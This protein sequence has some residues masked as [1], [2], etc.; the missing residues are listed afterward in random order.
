MCSRRY[1]CQC[2]AAARGPKNTVTETFSFGAAEE[3]RTIDNIAEYR[4]WRK[5]LALQPG[6]K[7]GFFP[8]MG[9]LHEG[10]LVC[11]CVSVCCAFRCHC[12]G[13]NFYVS[14]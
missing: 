11:M 7:I 13:P 4:V 14:L 9:A 8:T 6:E 1:A 5:S 2:A 3:M 12:E 10:H